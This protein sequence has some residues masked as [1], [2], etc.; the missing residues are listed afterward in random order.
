MHGWRRAGIS[1]RSSSGWAEAVGAAQAAIL[2]L[3][4]LSLCLSLWAIRTDTPPVWR[5]APPAPAT[6]AG[7]PIFETVFDYT[8]ET[9]QAHSPAV[10]LTPEGFDLLWFQGSAEAQADVDIHAASFSRG[11]EGWQ[12]G[13]VH[14]LLTRGDLG[15][16]MVPRQA[17]VTLGNTIENEGVPGALYATVASVGG[18]AMASV[19]DVRMAGGRPEWARKL[20][21]SP[22]LGRSNL[23]KSPMVEYA[24]GTHAL[25]AY[26]EMGATYGLLARLDA[27]GRVRDTRRIA[28]AR[29]AGK[30]IQPMIVALDETRALAFLR[31][32]GPSHQLLI[33]RTQDGGQSWSPAAP[34]GIENPSSP[35]AALNLG[36]G[37]ILMAINDEAENPQRLRLILG[38]EEG[39]DWRVLRIFEG[40]GALRYPMLRRLPGGEI[41]LAY[42]RGTKRGVVAHVFNPAWVAAQ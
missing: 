32:F 20:N 36:D 30:P 11:A 27:R 6:A 26:F 34:S 9:G 24:D 38:T 17:V 42:S 28:A 8:L 1:A 40:A 15:A 13:P 19:A 39:A 14:L 33:S 37:S 7:A 12:A 4:V 10:R 18:W 25:P 23:V 2:G 21:L 16:A 22:V 3:A 29:G 5:F 35:V 41:V 31:D